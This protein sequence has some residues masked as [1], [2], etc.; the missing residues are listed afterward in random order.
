MD[1]LDKMFKYLEV[2]SEVAPSDDLNTMIK[3]INESIQKIET[4]I[5][6]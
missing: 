3:Q 1:N 2:M 4:A 6:K 5:K